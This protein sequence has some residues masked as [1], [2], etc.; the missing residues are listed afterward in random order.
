MV[1]RCTSLLAIA[2]GLLVSACRGPVEPHDPPLRPLLYTEP[3]DGDEP[4]PGDEM[5]VRPDIDPVA[6]P[7]SWGTHSAAHLPRP[8]GAAATAN[9]EQLL[10]DVVD[11]LLSNDDDRFLAHVLDAE[12]LRDAARMGEDAARIR[13]AELL[14]E[15]R[16]TLDRFDPGPAA[17]A[18]P[19]GLAA[20]L[21]PTQVVAGRPRLVDGQL[22]EDD[23]DAE[24]RWGSEVTLQLIGHDLTFTVRFPQLLRR[25]DGT[26]ALGAAP[27]VDARFASWRRLGMDRKPELMD[28]AHA[29]W[30]LTAGSYWHYRV[31]QP[32]A[33]A[34]ADN[35]DG[36]QY[37]ILT[38]DGYRDEVV[39]ITRWDGWRLVRLRRL[40]D[41]PARTS[42]SPA[43]LVTPHHVY[44][45]PRDCVR[46]A[47]DVGWI[48]AWSERQTP[49]LVDG[50]EHG[51]S[52]GAGGNDVRNNVYRSA[53][54]PVASAVPAGTFREA[55]EITR[56]TPGGRETRFF[57][58]GIGFVM[59]RQVAGITTTVEEL[60]DYRILP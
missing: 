45:C 18:R 43:L 37:G 24:L 55:V 59:T 9:A 51:R 15:A 1:T 10:I 14:D 8:R 58:H 36:E 5:W 26:W 49:L 53:P 4:L 27:T 3:I 28:A 57:A 44:R 22:V 48:L 6:W 16:E 50:I 30:P 17:A 23:A 29:A 42:E 56:S 46:N 25:S 35:D 31:R 39:D 21:E 40:Y 12:G 41:D 47:D 11:A 52:W 20:L 32:T 60:V 38:D 2:L 54:D 19:G 33:G 34:I 13:S 7:T